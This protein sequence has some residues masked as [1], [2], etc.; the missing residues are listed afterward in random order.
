M[1]INHIFLTRNNFHL[2]EKGIILHAG[3]LDQSLV[4]LS[5]ATLYD[6]NP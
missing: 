2:T 5:S 3:V 4:L 1:N 6:K